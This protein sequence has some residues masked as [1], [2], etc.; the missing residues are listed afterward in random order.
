MNPFNNQLHSLRAIPSKCDQLSWDIRKLLNRL[1]FCKRLLECGTI[2]GSE[3]WFRAPP[4]E[5]CKGMCLISIVEIMMVIGRL[6][7]YRWMVFELVC[8]VIYFNN[9]S[10]N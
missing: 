9:Y 6:S 7:Y 8:F 1:E 4:S 10:I 3:S 5:L 2:Y